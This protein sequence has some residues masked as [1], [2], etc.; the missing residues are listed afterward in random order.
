M[1]DTTLINIKVDDVGYF[2]LDYDDSSNALVVNAG[3]YVFYRDIFTFVD[4]FKDLSKIYNKNK[5][6]ALVL[7][8]FRGGAF[9]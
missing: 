7:A 5:I 8:C 1:N 9:I 6:K 2:N 3:R 4:R